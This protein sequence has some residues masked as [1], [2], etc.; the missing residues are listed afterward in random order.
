L[1]PGFAC[2]FGSPN[3]SLLDILEDDNVT[4]LEVVQVK[5][6]MLGNRSVDCRLILLGY[7]G[8]PE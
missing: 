3:V 7:H 1:R 6:R 4:V 5:G 2:I 8:C